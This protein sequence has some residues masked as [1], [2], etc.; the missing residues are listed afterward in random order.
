M[1]YAINTPKLFAYMSFSSNVLLGIKKCNNSKIIEIK[2][3][4]EKL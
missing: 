4:K 3:K 2:N 1:K